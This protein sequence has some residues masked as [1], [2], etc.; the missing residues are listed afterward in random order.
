MDGKE[1]WQDVQRMVLRAARSDFTTGQ[2]T[3][4]ERQELASAATP[5]TTPL[6]QD[7]AVWR[8]A[9]LWLAAVASIGTVFVAIGGYQDFATQIAEAQVKANPQ[10]KDL[11]S[12]QQAQYIEQAVSGIKTQFGE[13]NLDVIDGISMFLLLVQFAGAVMVVYAA[14]R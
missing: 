8:K 13:D 7:Y 10:W 3:D 1:I 2:A 5:I 14:Q 4:A 6:V 12:D 11:S 9:M